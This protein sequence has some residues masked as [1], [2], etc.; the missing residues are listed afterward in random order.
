MLVSGSSVLDVELKQLTESTEREELAKLTPWSFK[1]ENSRAAL[2]W[3]SEIMT[4]VM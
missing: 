3:S 2:Y 1:P 4:R